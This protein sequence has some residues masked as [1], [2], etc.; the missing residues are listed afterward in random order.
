MTLAHFV[1]TS[2]I[3]IM[4]DRYHYLHD[5]SK[6]SLKI[7][8]FIQSHNSSRTRSALESCHL[9][10]LP[11][12]V[13][14]SSLFLWFLCLFYICMTGITVSPLA[15]IRECIPSCHVPLISTHSLIQSTSGI[16]FQ[17]F[18]ISVHA[19]IISALWYF[20]SLLICLSASRS[21]CFWYILNFA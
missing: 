1:L 20:S 15:H 4:E 8:R 16:S 17:F 19:F 9:D 14:T 18:L 13:L 7:K 5:T 3:H 2:I 21:Y 10:F 6:S 12:W 11:Y